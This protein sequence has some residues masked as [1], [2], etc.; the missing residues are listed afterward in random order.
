MNTQ[1][2]ETYPEIWARHYDT[3]TEEKRASFLL[4]LKIMKNQGNED[5]EK[6]FHVL[7]A[8]WVAEK[9]VP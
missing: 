5:A 1:N 7:V 3:L 4:T 8:R 6:A 9:P 2:T